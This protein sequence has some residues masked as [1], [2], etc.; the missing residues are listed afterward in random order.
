MS[1]VVSVEN[2]G[3]APENM[4]PGVIVSEWNLFGLARENGDLDLYWI[5]RQAPGYG[6]RS[7]PE[8]PVS[9]FEEFRLLHLRELTNNTR[10]GAFEIGS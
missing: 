8:C 3:Y 6:D 5:R 10:G 1:A 2:H 9:K 7:V 4:G